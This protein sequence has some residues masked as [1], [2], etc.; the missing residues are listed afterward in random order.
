[1]LVRLVLKNWKSCWAE[2]ELS[3]IATGEKQ[4]AETLANIKKFRLKLLP[5]TAI[6]GPNASG[7]S[8][9]IAALSFAKKFITNGLGVDEPIPVKRFKFDDSREKRPLEMQ[10]DLLINELIYEYEFA[11]T[12]RTV[13]SESLSL[14]NS[15]S[16][17]VLFSRIDQSIELGKGMKEDAMLAL[18][19]QTTRS[20]TLF[21][22]NSVLQNFKEFRSVYDWFDKTLLIE[23]ENS[24][25][26]FL[27]KCLNSTSAIKELSRLLEDF[28]TG[29][30][31]LVTESI[32]AAS[33][34]IA[35]EDLRCLRAQLKEGEEV[36]F[37]HPL[38]RALFVLSKAGDELEVK[39]VMAC[40]KTPQGSTI[41]F[42]MEELSFGMNRLIDLAPALLSLNHDPSRVVFIDDLD[43]GF[44]T[45]LTQSLIRRFLSKCNASNRNQLI[46]TAQDVQLM[47]QE[48]LR[49]DE[50]WL[51]DRDLLCGSS[52]TALSEFKDIRN[53]HNLIRSYLM[54]RLGGLPK[55]VA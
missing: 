3:L 12:G 49:R 23:N 41:T 18:S 2:S 17:K 44:H 53:D 45:L 11:V 6:Y 37:R 30:H 35:N 29:V 28:D 40:C 10:F 46:F 20:N 42:S 32:N 31:E 14:I 25:Y 1:M 43:Q 5:L 34:P 47:D 22:T 24:K 51:M 19:A 48:L 33:L 9:L 54:G 4:H 8:N 52:L 16:K 21:L 39:K 55:V 13:V 27:P 7:K 38:T 36:L 15:S 50:I 26:R